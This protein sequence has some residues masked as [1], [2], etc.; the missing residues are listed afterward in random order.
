MPTHPEVHSRYEDHTAFMTEEP[1]PSSHDP[2]FIE[3]HAMSRDEQRYLDQC[4]RLIKKTK[5]KK[6]RARKEATTADVRSY[7][8]EFMAA[9]KAEYDSWTDNNVF[10]L[11]DM[12][13]EK[14]R[15]FV[16]GRWVLTI[17]NDKNGNFEKCK[18]RWVLRGF[19][20]RQNMINKQIHQHL[21]DQA[22]AWHVRWQ[23]YKDGR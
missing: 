15:N 8:K 16:T 18:A 20:D 22:S 11:V 2:G 21:P 5:P 19:Q 14:V 3:S 17:K 6:V 10:E 13:E 4:Y 12:R 1:T 9:K 23:P 7:T